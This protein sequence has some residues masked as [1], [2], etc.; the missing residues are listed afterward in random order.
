[1][2]DEFIAKRIIEG[3]LFLSPDPLTIRDISSITG[4]KPSLVSYCLKELVD[5]YETRGINISS[6]G[7]AYRMLSNPDIAPYVDRFKKYKEG[8]TLSR[9]AL[10][11]LAVVAYNQPATRKDVEQI[12]GVNV[13]AII[14]KLLDMR[15]I[16][17]QGRAP[18]PGRPVLLGTTKKFLQT[19]GIE[20]IEDLPYRDEIKKA[21]MEAVQENANSN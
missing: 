20:K 19:F 15:L 4:M 7:G 3:I 21:G 5:D 11:T 12:R 8:V 9:A 2:A 6:A 10:E 18:Q 14:N 17:I 13:D 1:M 16:R